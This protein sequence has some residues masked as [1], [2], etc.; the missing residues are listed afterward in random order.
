MEIEGILYWRRTIFMKKK[1]V[2]E[3]WNEEKRVEE[4]QFLF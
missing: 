2:M 1:M 3:G 4:E